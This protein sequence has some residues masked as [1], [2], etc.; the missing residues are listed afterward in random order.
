MSLFRY[1]LIVGTYGS[2]NAPD[3]TIT[4]SVLIVLLDV[5]ILYISFSLTIESTFSLIYIFDPI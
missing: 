3:A 5:T 1:L 2:P 4:V